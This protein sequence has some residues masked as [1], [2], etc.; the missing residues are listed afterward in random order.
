MIDLIIPRGSSQLVREIQR[1]AKGVPVLGHSEGVCH[2]YVDQD[3]SIDKAIDV[4]RDSKCDYPAACNAMET[5]LVHRDLL[6][7]PIFDQI[8]DMLRTEHVKIHAG[9]RFAS[10]LTFSPNEVKSLRTEY[11]DLECC[12]EVVDSMHDAVDHIHKYGSSH[13]DVIVTENEETAEQFLQQVDSACV[14]WNSSSRFADGYRFGLGAEV[15]ISTARIH[16]RG[17][18]GLEGLLTTKWILRGEGHTVADFSEQGS[19]KYLHENIPVPQG[20]FRMWSHT[21]TVQ[22]YQDL[23]DRGWRRCHALKFQPSKSHK[24]ILKKMSKFISKGELP[25]GQDDGMGADPSRPPCRKAKD[26]RKERRLQKEQMRQH[27]D[28]VTSVVSPTPS[29][30]HPSQANQPKTLEDFIDESL[31]DDSSHCLEVRLVRSNPPS[32]QFKASFDASYQVYK[33]YQMAIHKD[34]P[35]KPSESQVRLVP[36]SFEDP[37]FTASYEQSVALYSRYQM[38]I[39]GD[40]PS[41]CRMNGNRKRDQRGVNFARLQESGLTQQSKAEYSPDGPEVGY[42]SFH[43]QYWLDGRIVAVGVIDI[44]PTCV[45]SVYLYYHPEFASLSLGSY[46]ALSALFC[47]SADDS[48]LC[49]DEIRERTHIDCRHTYLAFPM[50]ADVRLGDLCFK[51]GVYRCFVCESRAFTYV[52]VAAVRTDG[53]CSYRGNTLVIISTQLLITYYFKSLTPRVTECLVC[54][55]GLGEGSQQD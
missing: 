48:S 20:N 27:V 6:R 16:A 13:T 53:L 38:A 9:P 7:T 30:T 22:D 50:C 17:P 41:E 29:T 5:L 3:A 2:I 10:Y 12:I 11:G 23:I 54:G 43:Q 32:P 49:Q 37:Q 52:C 14:F 46:S 1:A 31:P 44:L 39:H 18:V 42:G 35:D 36:V 19:M 51:V 45:S 24:K 15:G 25:T 21:M 55:G 28:G 33:L 34:P 4:V 26:L 40:D 8:I 47:G